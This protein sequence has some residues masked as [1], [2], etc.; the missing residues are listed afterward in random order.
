VAQDRTQGGQGARF[1]RAGVLNLLISGV[2]VFLWVRADWF[3]ILLFSLPPLVAGLVLVEVGWPRWRRER[4]RDREADPRH[5]IA[6]PP[7]GVRRS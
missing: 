1:L 5:P 2:F 7:A 3:V 4:A 6:D